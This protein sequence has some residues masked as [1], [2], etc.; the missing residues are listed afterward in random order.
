LR[1]IENEEEEMKKRE[2]EEINEE[3]ERTG[4]N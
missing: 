1:V 4:E 2:K 3:I